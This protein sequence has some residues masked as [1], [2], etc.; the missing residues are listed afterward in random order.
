MQGKLIY[1]PFLKDRDFLFSP[2]FEYVKFLV[3][4]KYYFLIVICIYVTFF[5]S[6]SSCIFHHTYSSKDFVA[7]FKKGLGTT[8]HVGVPGFLW[9]DMG[10]QNVCGHQGLATT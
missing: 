6:F 1:C 4:A 7:T 10:G 9:K 2:N 8:S 5:F 3:G